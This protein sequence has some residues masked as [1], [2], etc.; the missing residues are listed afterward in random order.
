MLNKC[1]ILLAFLL[2]LLGSYG[3]CGN[4]DNDRTTAVLKALESPGVPGRLEMDGSESYAQSGRELISQTYSVIDMETGETVFGPEVVTELL[5]QAFIRTYILPGDAPVDP[6]G[7]IEVSGDFLVMLEVEDGTGD[8]D[9]ATSVISLDAQVLPGS[10]ESCNAT[11]SGSS[12]EPNLVACPLDASCFSV[13]I[14]ENVL[15]R[16]AL[17]NLTITD[18]TTMWIRACGGNG[19]SGD[20]SGV[21]KGGKSGQGGFAQTITTVSEYQSTFGTSDMYY[22]LGEVGKHGSGGGSGGASTIVSDKVPEQ[23]DPW[24]LDNLV[25]LAGGGGG[26]GEGTGIHEGGNGGAGG[27]ACSDNVG[28]SATGVGLNNGE[29]GGLGGGGTDC[30]QNIACGGGGGSGSADPGNQGF[31]GESGG[32]SMSSGPK[33]W[34]NETPDIGD[35][36]MGGFTKGCLDEGSGG[37]GGGFGGGGGGG[38][39]DNANKCFGGGGGGSYASASTTTDSV[40]PSSNICGANADGELVITFN[41]DP[42]N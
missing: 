11:C 20:D 13:D 3:G 28:E 24:I 30:N 26:G 8:K 32:A 9:T 38:S 22:Y 5:D 27:L 25:V 6:D 16:A 23:S 19:G 35:D 33:G 10:S 34:I 14:V 7:V 2:I 17:V 37:G 42:G 41:L 39:S 1:N 31:G 12:N 29:R 4:G 18:H 15:D 40:A 21:T 36:G